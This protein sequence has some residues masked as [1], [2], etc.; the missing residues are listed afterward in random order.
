Y[1]I[2]SGVQRFSASRRRL[3][4]A[5]QAPLVRARSCASDSAADRRAH[6]HFLSVRGTNPVSD[7]TI[8]GRSTVRLPSKRK[9]ETNVGNRVDRS[10][11]GPRP[12]HRRRNRT[13]LAPGAFAGG[14]PRT[15]CPSGVAQAGGLAGT[16][17]RRVGTRVL[18]VH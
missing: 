11:V 9:R 10:L 7:C 8:N 13:R 6:T 3:L 5:L 17:R 18:T 1:V 4:V 12:R 15:T 16:R 2:R 14:C